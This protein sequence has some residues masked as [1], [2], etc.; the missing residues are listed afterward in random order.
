MEP[1]E[2]LEI[3][4]ADA[5]NVPAHNAVVCNSGTSALHLALESFQFPSGSEVIVPEFTM[6]AC[7]RAVTMAGLTPVF[8][9]CEDDLLIDASKI[10]AAVTPMTVAV[11]PVHVY[12]RQCD[13][14][15]ISSVAS[16]FDL[17]VIED[18]AEFHGAPLSGKAY[19][20][21]W[22]FYRN[23]IVAGEEGGAVVFSDCKENI[24]DRARCIRCQGFT[25]EHDFRHH[26]R[27]VNSRMPNSQANLVRQSLQMMYRNISARRVAEVA[28]NRMIPQEH[29]GSP[30]EVPW[31][32]DVHNATD[33][34]SIVR[35]LNGVR[36]PARRAFCPMSRQEEYRTDVQ[37][38]NAD[39]MYES[40][41]YLPLSPT[42]SMKELEFWANAVCRL[43]C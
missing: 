8:V 28:L 25:A 18:C 38:L 16:E 26:P 20:F 19:A 13:M 11:M 42:L 24:A 17:K 2:V 41:F 27:G 30:R 9:D 15:I 5:V 29:H 3:E 21:C 23:K 32:Y 10:E 40:V 37:F 39:R 31:V 7:A 36:I 34:S 6:I 4:W 12:G 33:A 14:E 43:I 35:K 22:S 1:Y